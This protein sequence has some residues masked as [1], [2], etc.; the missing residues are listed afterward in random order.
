MSFLNKMK[1]GHGVTVDHDLSTG[2]SSKFLVVDEVLAR[3]LSSPILTGRPARALWHFRP[4]LCLLLRRRSI[5]PRN[6]HPL[7]L[8]T[9]LLTR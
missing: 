3:P 2:M 1:R 9:R 5:P 7:T 8:R 6:R 4:R